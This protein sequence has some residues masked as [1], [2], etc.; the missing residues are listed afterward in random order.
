MNKRQRISALADITLQ[1]NVERYKRAKRKGDARTLNEVR[2][3]FARFG[4]VEQPDG[5]WKRPEAAS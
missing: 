2:D 4:L 3:L 5:T 1:D